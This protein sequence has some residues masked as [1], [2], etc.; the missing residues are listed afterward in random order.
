MQQDFMSSSNALGRDPIA[1]LR[2][3]SGGGASASDKAWQPIPVQVKV[4]EDDDGNPIYE[5]KLVGSK[6]SQ[7]DGFGTETVDLPGSIFAPVKDKA[8]AGAEGAAEGKAQG[9]ANVAN[10][11][12]GT[13]AKIISAQKK[14]ESEAKGLGET[15]VAYRKLKA[16]MPALVEVTNEL[17]GLAEVA[18]YTKGG[19][20]WDALVRELGF[21]PGKGATASAKYGAIVKNQVMPL[22]KATLG[23]AFTNEERKAMEATMGDESLSA[24]EKHEQLDAFMRSKEL[25][26]ETM[27]REIGIKDIDAPI[28]LDAVNPET[29]KP[30]FLGFE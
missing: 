3:I 12:A 23:A 20:A 16:S 7:K 13:K 11:I 25:S 22:L 8:A 14:A 15:K 9:E 26:L 19:R 29:T 4:D 5:T 18:T 27:E 30:K 1:G 28:S 2:Q 24:S 10:I 17:K 21:K 6:Y